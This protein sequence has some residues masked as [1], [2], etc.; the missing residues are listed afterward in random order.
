M[1][2]SNTTI[3]EKTDVMDLDKLKQ[4]IIDNINKIEH[5]EKLEELRIVTDYLAVPNLDPD[6]EEEVL[7][8]LDD[9]DLEFER[10]DFITDEESRRE[11]DEWLRK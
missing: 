1:V 2:K 4:A 6:N 8:M 7:R 5:L 10:G 3:N 9:A 11:I